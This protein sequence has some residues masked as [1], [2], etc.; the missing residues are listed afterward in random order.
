MKPGPSPRTVAG[1]TLLVIAGAFAAAYF[2]FGWWEFEPLRIPL[3]SQMPVVEPFQVD[4]SG[5]YEVNLILDWVPGYSMPRDARDEPWN[6]VDLT[7]T[8]RT[9][10]SQVAAGSSRESPSNYFGTADFEGQTLGRFAAEAGIPYDLTISV[11]SAEASIGRFNPRV[12]VW[13]DN[14]R[15][16]FHS[17]YFL[18]FVLGWLGI[19]TALPGAALLVVPAAWR[20]VT[21]RPRHAV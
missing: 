10:S 11:N 7:W 16:P 8:V 21:R 12:C 1:V 6:P 15:E 19:L 5:P 4:L 18:G 9:N 2:K 3:P 13:S 14:R 20:W 17:R